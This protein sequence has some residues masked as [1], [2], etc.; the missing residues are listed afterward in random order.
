MKNGIIPPN[1]HFDNLSPSVAPFYTNLQVPTKAMSWPS[2][3]SGQ[4][5]RAS[6][7]SFGK[8]PDHKAS[9]SV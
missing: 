6:I 1:L 5:R 3:V 2:P 7:N 8:F 4:P 9:V